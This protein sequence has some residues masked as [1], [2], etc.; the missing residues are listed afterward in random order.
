M[1]VHADARPG[2]SARRSL[3]GG[4]R[5]PS[6]CAGVA[7]Q[8]RAGSLG[9]RPLITLRRCRS[10]SGHSHT[11]SSATAWSR[12]QAD[13]HQEAD[14]L[15]AG[16]EAREA[17]EAGELESAQSEGRPAVMA[18]VHSQA[19][20][21]AAPPLKY[22]PTSETTFI[23]WE[24]MDAPA[25]SPPPAPPRAPQPPPAPPRAPQPPPPL[26]RHSQPPAALHRRSQPPSVQEF[27]AGPF[28]PRSEAAELLSPFAG[29]G[30]LPE[31]DLGL[32]GARGGGDGDSASEG[33]GPGEHAAPADPAL[34]TTRSAV[35]LP[36][37]QG[38]PSARR[39]QVRPFAMVPCLC[40]KGAARRK[41][42][43]LSMCSLRSALRCMYTDRLCHFLRQYPRL[44]ARLHAGAASMPVRLVEE[45][46]KASACRRRGWSLPSW[47]PICDGLRGAAVAPAWHATSAARLQLLGNQL[48]MAELDSQ[49]APPATRAMSFS[50]TPGRVKRGPGRGG[51]TGRG[52]GKQGE[53]TRSFRARA[54]SGELRSLM[55]LHV[56]EHGIE[57]M[58]EVLTDYQCEPCLSYPA[59]PALISFPALRRSGGCQASGR[60]RSMWV[61]CWVGA[62]PAHQRP[63]G[64]RQSAAMPRTCINNT[65]INFVRA[66]ATGL[67]DGN[68]PWAASCA[69]DAASEHGR[70]P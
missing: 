3:G 38:L 50:G 29:V 35:A 47:E 70:S 23:P 13:E 68:R 7:A 21:R 25:N 11:S 65:V 16:E 41:C 45:R 54:R 19:G 39:L 58:A 6:V 8:K 52:G 28:A 66:S 34:A 40:G 55:A 51:V 53:Q 64:G 49:V 22:P 18:H 46:S 42:T 62:G 63:G 37:P 61:A 2:S 24:R 14:E 20:R 1:Q 33:G 44:P 48:Q 69:H 36:P 67:H 17:A 26:H 56:Y 31:P 59:L 12:A 43:P 27:A 15:R 32:G 10:E 5:G 60:D 4:R 57:Q 9:V 30:P